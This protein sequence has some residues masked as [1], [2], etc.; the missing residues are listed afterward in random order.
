MKRAT[1]AALLVLLF[2][3]CPL[4]AEPL[5]LPSPDL[6]GGWQRV[7]IPDV[8]TI[9]IP[10]SMEVQN[11]EYSRVMHAATNLPLQESATS[12]SRTLVIQQE[13]LNRF[14]PLAA[15]TY[16]RIVVETRLGSAGDFESLC[17]RFE[18][19][20]D[21]LNEVSML[22]R[23]GVENQAE[24][25]ST[26]ILR[27]DPPSVEL[28]NGMQAI[29]LSYRRQYQR[30]PPVWVTRFIFQNHDRAHELTISYR[31]TDKSRW[32]PEVA[33]ALATF[34]ITDI[35]GQKN[36][37]TPSLDAETLGLSSQDLSSAAWR[38]AD[39][40][41]CVATEPSLDPQFREYGQQLEQQPGISN[42]KNQESNGAPAPLFYRENWG[43]MLILSAILTWGIGLMPPLLVRFAFMQEPMS[44]KAASVFVVVFFFLHFLNCL[45]NQAASATRR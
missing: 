35:R 17:S 39:S 27:W 44:E 7:Q 20:P 23:R 42:T 16:V 14:D 36:S 40:A 28:V 6:R 22:F 8:G 45:Q 5:P 11:E 9:D 24:N 31:E 10:P 33:A 30:N 12:M 1:Q 13:G 4:L 25:L 2:G 43:T 37:P 18:V 34:R 29:R 38:Q 32:L 41:G 26:K 3:H 15:T 19:T 21:E